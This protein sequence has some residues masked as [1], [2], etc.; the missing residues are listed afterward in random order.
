MNIKS[1]NPEASALYE[2]QQNLSYNNKNFGLMNNYNAR[3]LAP[4]QY[5]P[6]QQ[7]QDY[8]YQNNRSMIQPEQSSSVRAPTSDPNNTCK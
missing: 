7:T 3:S 8:T 1:A 5:T 6:P 2:L 4:T